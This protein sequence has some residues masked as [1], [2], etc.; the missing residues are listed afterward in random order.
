MQDGSTY[1]ETGNRQMISNDIHQQ[2]QVQALRG[3]VEGPGC[4]PFVIL[5]NPEDAA[6][7]QSRISLRRTGHCGP[8]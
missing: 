1:A 7:P 5:G 6:P 8:S 4:S 3:P 2:F